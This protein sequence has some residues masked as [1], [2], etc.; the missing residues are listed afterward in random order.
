MRHALRL[1]VR[2]LGRV[3]P[4]PAVG[5]IIV[6]AEGHIVGRGWTQ[7]GGR[8]HAETMALAAAGA[9]AKGAT[10]YVTLEPCA[11]HG[12]TP[13]CADAVVAAGVARVVVAIADPDPRTAG[14]G[15]AK[16]E[17]AGITVTRDVLKDRAAFVAEGFFKRVTL[18]RPMVALKSAESADGFVGRPGS[19]VSITGESARNHGHLLRAMHDA[20]MAGIGTVVADD[21]LLTC[22]L[23]GMEDRSPIRVVIDTHL[24]LPPTS[25]L[26]RTAREHPVVVFT[27]AA[28][29][30]TLTNA[31][32]EIV[33]LP[34]TDRRM[35]L[36]AVMADLGRRGLTRILVEGG[37]TLE[38]AL[39][40]AGLVDRVHLYRAQHRLDAGLPGIGARVAADA[41]FQPFER[42]PLGPDILESYAL[43]G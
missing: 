19:R 11:H 32:V 35:D 40:D 37:P 23:P 10:A 7:P 6:S 38:G 42:R 18:G 2:G 1:A 21:P 17:A 20:I 27:T 43:K 5:C 24:R 15:I 26:V 13:P 41:R 34:A 28:G 30:D 36:G 33:R 8:P 3:A 14:K 16:L 9:Q 12:E 22:R 25:Q 39:L 31:E 4:N 29:S